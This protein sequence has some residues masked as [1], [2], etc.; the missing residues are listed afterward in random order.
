MLVPTLTLQ[1]TGKITK[2]TGE[3]FITAIRATFDIKKL[4]ALSFMTALV[5]SKLKIV[6][7][8]GY[9]TEIIWQYLTY[10]NLRRPDR[11]KEVK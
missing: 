9:A 11:G 2:H 7:V 10:N 1:V 6:P 8:T 4:D 3:Q 5:M